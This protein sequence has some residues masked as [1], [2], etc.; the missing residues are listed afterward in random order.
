V[1]RKER[2]AALDVLTALAAL[3]QQEPRLLGLLTS[4]SALSP[5]VAALAPAALL[6][7]AAKPLS[8][9]AAG[10]AA[11]AAPA[12]SD[13]E[14]MAAATGDDVASQAAD[15]EA[16][17]AGALSL[18]AFATQSAQLTAALIDESFVRTLLWLAH[19]P[20]SPRVLAGA[21]GLL[22]AL[23][24]HPAVAL[25]CGYQG[26]AVLLL[27]VLLH[28][29]GAPWPFLAG[30]GPATPADEDGARGAAA[31][32]LQRVMAD[33]TNGT[34]TRLVLEQLLPPGLVAGIAEGPPEAVLRMLAQVGCN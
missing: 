30:A 18:L 6:G 16:L 8:P 24:A 7:G 17:A 3:L 5:V 15:A 32:A 33:A 14:A 2:A 31:A 21:L 27:D 4:K 29:P 13:A 10:A 23:S 20:P 19:A 28:P 9:G 1:S 22:R 26:G 25:V 34:R 12:A 11:Q